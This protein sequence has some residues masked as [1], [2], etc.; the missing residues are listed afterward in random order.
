VYFAPIILRKK[1]TKKSVTT[2]KL[3]NSL[4]FLGK[5]LMKLIPGCI[6]VNKK[7]LACDSERSGK[8]SWPILTDGML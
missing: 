8:A 2:E 6:D 1:I 5:M 3:L 7:I 4:S